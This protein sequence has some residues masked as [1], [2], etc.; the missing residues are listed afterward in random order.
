[1]RKTVRGML[2][3]AFALAGAHVHAGSDPVATVSIDMEGCKKELETFCKDVTPGEGRI[4][5]CL[6]AFE[7]RLSNRC[8]HTLYD[9]SAKLEKAV[10]DLKYVAAE[11]GK[12]IDAQCK[13]VKPGKGRIAAC[14][15]NAEAKVSK[16]C[17]QALKDTG[18]VK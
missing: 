18:A 4:L 12:D 9:A 14:L 5:S 15:K 3:C 13:D 17:M 6:Y 10:S 16:S 11:C 1:M 8:I 7:D 2:F